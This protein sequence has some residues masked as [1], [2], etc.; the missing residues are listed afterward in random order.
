MAAA[1]RCVCVTMKILMYTVNDSLPRRRGGG[2]RGRGRRRLERHS[3]RELLQVVRHRVGAGDELM[4]VDHLRVRLLELGLGLPQT[5]LLRRPRTHRGGLEPMA[6]AAKAKAAA[7][8]GA[9]PSYPGGDESGECKDR[10]GETRGAGEEVDFDRLRLHGGSQR[11]L[12]KKCAR[13][14][15]PLCASTR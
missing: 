7:S 10:G 9:Y 3:E 1:V 4:F 12:K 6:T 2:G 8:L 11:R 5:R 14:R 15:A 13:S